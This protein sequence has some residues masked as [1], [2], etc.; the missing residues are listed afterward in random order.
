MGVLGSTLSLSKR[1]HSI[2]DIVKS[3]SSIPMLKGS[4]L[5]FAAKGNGMFVDSFFNSRTTGKGRSSC[6]SDK[7]VFVLSRK[8]LKD[9]R[10]SF[11]LPTKPTD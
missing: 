6:D 3:E 1:D 4:A 7:S 11:K 9:L 2:S 8:R 10:F 5:M